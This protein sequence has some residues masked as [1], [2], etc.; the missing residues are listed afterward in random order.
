MSPRGNGSAMAPKKQ[1]DTQKGSPT[2]LLA[3]PLPPSL[4][5]LTEDPYIRI[6]DGVQRNG[7]LG[8]GCMVANQ[9]S[10]GIR[11]PSQ[12][13][14]S[15]LWQRPRAWRSVA[16]EPEP[17]WPPRPCRSPRRC[18]CRSWPSTSAASARAPA[19]TGC[20]LGSS[21]SFLGS[22]SSAPLPPGEPPASPLAHP[23]CIIWG[24]EEICRVPRPYIH[25]GWSVWG[26]P[27]MS[28]CWHPDGHPVVPAAPRRAPSSARGSSSPSSWPARQRS[29]RQP[30]VRDTRPEGWWRRA[31]LVA[32]LGD[33]HRG[34]LIVPGGLGKVRAR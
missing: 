7:D 24:Q 14:F 18:C 32:R 8:R 33:G 4:L 15:P 2:F 26:P 9:G 30:P 6:W 13:D 19:R 20:R 22:C 3:N 11:D 28:G 1:G 25:L 16:S 31:E 5:F 29:C 21:G 12:P 34:G 17:C 23:F 10:V 27:G